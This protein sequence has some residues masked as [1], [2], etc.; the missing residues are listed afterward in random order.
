M[1][2]NTIRKV[3]YSAAGDP[4]VV[5]VISAEIP[6]PAKNEIQVDVIYS[7]FSGADINM[8]LG[9]YPMQKPAPLTPGYCFV[10]RVSQKGAGATPKFQIGQLVGALTVYD[11]EA[12]KIN[13]AEKYV[14]AV[15]E[16]VDMR[17]ACGVIL[18]WNT[19]YSLITRGTKVTKGKRVFVHGLSGAVGYAIMTLCLLE[20]AEVYGTASPRN[21]DALRALGVT[22]YD[23]RDK[24]WMDAIKATGGAHVVYDPLGFESWDESWDV[25]IRNEPS[26]LVG[27]GGNLNVV[28]AGTGKPRSQFP[29][30]MRLLAKNGCLWTRRSTTFYYI[31]RDRATFMPDLEIIMGMLAEGKFEVPIK[32][33]WDMENIREPHEQW[34]SVPGMGSCLIRVAKDA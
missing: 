11:S 32:A 30:M 16:N 33:I 15:P 8:R 28:N 20:G 21:H 27:F 34:T 13:V 23:Y 12:E 14:I 26:T 7:G 19:A 24:K 22:P 29:A 2:T 18:D 31:D 9:S 3:H 5:S 6:P 1:A 17:E 4:S 25:L 10:G